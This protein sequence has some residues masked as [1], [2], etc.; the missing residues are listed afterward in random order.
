VLSFSGRATERRTGNPNQADKRRGR[1]LAGTCSAIWPVLAQKRLLV[2]MG[3]RRRIVRR[4]AIRYLL[5]NLP[6]A[7]VHR[8]GRVWNVFAR[9]LGEQGADGRTAL[10]WRWAFTGAC[11]SP[12]SL[13]SPLGR[14]PDGSELLSEASAGAELAARGSDPGGQVLHARL[15]LQWLVGELDAVP[16]WNAGAQCPHATDGAAVPRTP[17]AI[18]EAYH[19]SLLACFRY[20]RSGEAGSSEAS[21]TFG[22]AYGARQLLAWACGEES[23]GP[24]SGLRTTGRPTLYEISLD[25]RRA[26]TAIDHARND[27]QPTMVG[28]M[29]ATMESF[30]WLTGWDG[31]LSIDPHGH[32]VSESGSGVTRHWL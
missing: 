22:W 8:P 19:R 16:L 25:V 23:T 24:L 9:S 32:M 7:I 12:V 31:Q 21:R 18:E 28:R 6:E 15:V 10:A 29:E 4:V 26:M 17:A 30:L 2:T 20:P 5:D 13:S 1:A 14:P 11:P 27:D 3:S